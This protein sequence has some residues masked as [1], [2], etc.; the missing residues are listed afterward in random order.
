MEIVLWGVRGSICNPDRASQFYGA[1]TSCLEVRPTPDLLLVLDAG[2]GIRSLAETLPDSG[3]CHIL[4][5]HTHSD[6]VQGLPFFTPFFKKD[7]HITLYLPPHLERLPHE[8]FDGKNFPVTFAGLPAA[9]SLRRVDPASSVTLRDSGMDV[10]IDALPAN[11]PGGAYAYKITSPDACFLFSGDH[12][13]TDDPEVIDMT[14]RMLAGADLAVVDAMF[15]RSDHHPG[16]GHS[17]WEDWVREA[18]KA[19]LETLVLA[20]HTPEKTDLA[21]DSLQ[22]HFAEREKDPAAKT[23]VAVAREG[24]AFHLPGRAVIDRKTSDWLQAFI[25]SLAEF[26][27]ETVLLDHILSKTREI[28]VA[29]AGSIYLAE[30][31]ELVFAYAQNDTLFPDNAC[32]K[33]M[34]VN[35][36]LPATRESIAGYVACTRE[37]LNIDDVHCIPPGEPYSFNDSFDKKA[38]YVTRSMLTLPISSSKGR[39][40]GVLQLINSRSPRDGGIVPFSPAIVNSLRTLMREAAVH[41][42]ISEQV[43]QSIHRLLRI[44]MLHDPSETG[45]H[46]ERVGA[47]AAE[48]YQSWAERNGTPPERL[49]AFKSQLRLAAMVHDIGKVGISDSLLKKP[50]RLTDEEFAVMKTHTTLGAE[51][52]APETRD[53]AE[54]AHEISHHHHQKWNGTGYPPVNGSP[55]A[56][57]DIPLSARIT[58]IADVFDALVSPRCYKPAWP[59]ERAVALITEEAGRHFDPELVDCFIGLLDTLDMI[60]ARYPDIP[61]PGFTPVAC[62]G[63]T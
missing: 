42:E 29:D 41:L 36:R 34:Y 9:I 57:T 50:G 2:T 44:A 27:E 3:E 62:K 46:A 15:S 39:I 10:R 54:M 48:I 6:H 20:H 38:G 47:I 25:D 56:G 8:L 60:Y 63:G 18:E 32:N 5:T 12:E 26:R 52:F 1:N 23:R 55:L 51:L 28:A 33:S 13:I 35:M 14:G 21:L 22:R 17:A 30:G 37:I 7:W 31:D 49:R 45:P 58:A 19:G 40:L 53:I 24:M 59:A 11:H 4:I 61:Q 16:W 43:S